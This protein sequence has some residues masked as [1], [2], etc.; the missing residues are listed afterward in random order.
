MEPMGEAGTTPK[1][2]E[3]RL[4]R[5]AKVLEVDFEDGRSIRLPA[6]LLRVESPSADVQGHAPGEK[7][8]VAGRRYVGIMAIEPVGNY[9][10]RIVFDDLHETGI[11]SWTTL[12]ELG[13]NQERIWRKYLAELAA[14]GLSSDP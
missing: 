5:E 12:Y 11:Y 2:I 9:A 7:R 6:E 3:I 4:I 14:Q 10:I 8:I 13:R 1:P